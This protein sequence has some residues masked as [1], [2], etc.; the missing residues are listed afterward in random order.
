MELVSEIQAPYTLVISEKPDAA[1]RIA[2][3]LGQLFAVRLDGIEVF[4]VPV[5]FDGSHYVVCSAAGHLYGMGDP[6]RTRRVYPVFDLEWFPSDD[7]FPSKWSAAR[8]IS[9]GGVA[10]LA[11][12]RLSVISRL[13]VHAD[14]LVQAC[15]YDIEGETIGANIVS[16]ACSQHDRTRPSVRAKFSTLTKEEVRASFSNLKQIESSVV[17]AGRARHFVDFL[18]GINLS[19]AIS[20]SYRSGGNSFRNLTTGR[21]QGP[22]LAFVLEREIAAKAHVPLPFWIITAKLARNGKEFQALYEKERIYTQKEAEQVYKEISEEQSAKVTSI[23]ETIK[24]EHPP[25]P[26]NIGDLQREAF[27]LYRISPSQTLSLAEKLYL[28]AL[29]SY[30][31]TNSQKL[32]EAIGYS[33]IISNLV[34]CKEY[35]V[36]ASQ[37]EEG[38]RR[39]FPMQGFK[40]DP[41]HP[42][43]YPTGL[44]SNRVLD[45]REKKIY[46]LIV[47]RFLGAFMK[48]AISKQIKVDFLVGNRNF[49]SEGLVILKSGWKT[50]YSFY[51]SGELHLPELILQEDVPTLE[52]RLESKFTRAP[53]LHSESSLLERMESENVGTKAT[54]AETISTLAERGYI[55]SGNRGVLVLTETGLA[56]LEALRQNC[57]EII[58]SE[59]TRKTEQEIEAIMNGNE[60]PERILSGTVQAALK[61]LEQIHRSETDIGVSLRANGVSDTATKNVTAKDHEREV[62]IGKC[63]SCKNGELKVIRSRATNKRFIGCTSYPSGCRAGAPLP[64]R[65][66]IRRQG[67]A[68]TTCGWPM[69]SVRFFYR[70]EAP[71]IFCPNAQ[72]TGKLAQRR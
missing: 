60:K 39:R 61:V 1:R 30:P 64:Q 66:V 28:G 25:Y 54:R 14:R 49:H 67:K 22:T 13:A 8:R 18:W 21:V 2:N 62:I 47:R 44:V 12:R 72:C 55:C 65:G 29:I 27:R 45:P 33:R 58:S 19:R 68:C 42:A 23:Y 56:I 9:K 10:N 6:I 50:A 16:Y 24:N 37:M 46:D 63:P 40:D 35:T 17:E 4:D 34:S 15:D 11:S 53:L 41:A 7:L 20:E 5:A 26:F 3:S 51:N 71:W 52:V 32:P 38:M 69:I 43:I 57:P 70:G 36:Y 59:L 31:R 48:D